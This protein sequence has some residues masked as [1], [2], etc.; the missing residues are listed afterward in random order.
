MSLCQQCLKDSSEHTKTQWRKHQEQKVRQSVEVCIFCQKMKGNH[1]EKLWEIHENVVKTALMQR[2]TNKLQPLQQYD[3]I[4]SYPATHSGFGF[5][6]EDA[7]LPIFMPCIKCGLWLGDKESD[8]ADVIGEMCFKCFCEETGQEYTWHTVTL[9]FEEIQN[10]QK[11][12]VS[13]VGQ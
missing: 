10:R 8:L 5:W 12:S 2:K 9:T 11:A 3:R 4:K 1:S 13:E 7:V 6:S